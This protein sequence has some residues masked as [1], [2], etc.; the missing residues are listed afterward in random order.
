MGCLDATSVGV[1]SKYNNI[2]HFSYR[3]LLR[4]EKKKKSCFGNFA[5]SSIYA[6]SEPASSQHELTD[7]LTA[8]LKTQENSIQALT[9]SQPV[10]LD[11]LGLLYFGNCSTKTDSWINWCNTS[12]YVSSFPRVRL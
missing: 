9:D 8:S 1:S 4:M 12:S 10:P 3:L 5:P 2:F 6:A 7:F 11:L